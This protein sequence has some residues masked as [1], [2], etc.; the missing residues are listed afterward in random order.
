MGYVVIT[1]AVVTQEFILD[2]A[3]H[4]QMH[5][6]TVL[7]SVLWMKANASWKHLYTL[8]CSEEP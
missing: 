6:K 7:S 4:V 8:V 1:S 3:S 2:H 5:M